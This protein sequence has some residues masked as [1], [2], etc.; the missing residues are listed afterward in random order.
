MNA[1]QKDPEAIADSLNAQFLNTNITFKG[2][3]FRPQSMA[4]ETLISQI[5]KK[6]DPPI[7]AYLYACVFLYV[8]AED[9]AKVLASVKTGNIEGIMDFAANYNSEDLDQLIAIINEESE[10]IRLAKVSIK[11][12]SGAKTEGN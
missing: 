12:S 2:I 8:H 4:T 6:F 10:K 11:S 7:S 5:L 1:E 3:Q 9:K